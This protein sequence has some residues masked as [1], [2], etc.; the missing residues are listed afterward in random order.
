MSDSLRRTD[1]AVGRASAGAEADGETLP[2]P[3]RAGTPWGTL[4]ARVI[5]VVS[6]KGG[7]GKT[8]S[9]INLGATFA[10]AG[11]SVLLIGTDPQ[12]GISRSLGRDKYDLDSGLLDVF[13]AH[14]PLN[15]LAYPT[16][17]ERLHFVTPNV[18]TLAEEEEF[19]RLMEH[20]SDTFLR[21]VDRAR[22]LYDTILID[23]PPGLGPES[24]T[25]LLASDSYL[26]PVQAEE[27]CRDS[28][29]RLLA[30]IQSFRDETHAESNLSGAEFAEAPPILEGLFL[31][32]AN[33]RTRMGRH[34]AERVAE[35][36]GLDLFACA[37]PRTARLAEM[38]L[39]G[40]PAVI[41]DRRSAGS[42]AYFDLMDEIVARWDSRRPAGRADAARA[43]LKPGNG[44]AR[45]GPAGN[46][47]TLAAAAGLRLPLDF[48]L[49]ASDD[50]DDDDS[51]GVE[52]V[53][54]GLSAAG[55][56]EMVSL[57]EMIE[58]EEES[59]LVAGDDDWEERRWGGD[60]ERPERFH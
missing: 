28:L 58:N 26:V 20:E 49:G 60:I 8:T 48:D 50:A 53:W 43:P 5:S 17:V 46:V 34:V 10:L 44:G 57:D 27:L 12:C 4:S 30:F 51:N 37:V 23:C 31:T 36:Y 14:V 59:L 9:T 35:E 22:N 25:S 3:P 39:R 38:A 1:R 41:Y 2:L 18:W 47:F 45:P 52:P 11:H 40:K 32:M 56:P 6:R 24:K 13:Q 16:A 15:H 55:E 21:A 42:R 19:K 7:V 54:D 33:A 29:G